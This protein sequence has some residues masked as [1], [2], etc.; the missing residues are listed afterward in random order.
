MNNSKSP[1]Y[2]ETLE[3]ISYRYST[4]RKA[5]SQVEDLSS[6][7]QRKKVPK[8]ENNVNVNKT[9]T[10]NVINVRAIAAKLVEKLDDPNSYKFFCMVA[11]NL[12][13]NYIWLS[14]EQ[15]MTG[16]D[17]KKYFSFLCNIELKR[18]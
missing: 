4:R 1:T 14:L 18:K 12:P 11:W 6:V 10:N 13:E 7:L 3:T 17:P 5:V 9:N 15:A 16:H 2:S 8:K